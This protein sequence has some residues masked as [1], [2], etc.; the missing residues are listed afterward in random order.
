MDRQ[1]EGPLAIMPLM[2]YAKNY[3]RSNFPQDYLKSLPQPRFSKEH[4]L[5]RLYG[6]ALEKNLE[7]HHQS[8]HTINDHVTQCSPIASVLQAGTS[9]SPPRPLA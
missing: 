5:K 6:D 3:F 9:A 1:T 2:M 4:L 7:S 8:P